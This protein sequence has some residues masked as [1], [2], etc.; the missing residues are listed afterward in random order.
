MGSSEYKGVY[1][2]TSK[3]VSQI[4][5]SQALKMPDNH[6]LKIPAVCSLQVHGEKYYLGTYDDEADAARAFDRVASVLGRPLNFPEGNE[7]EIVGPR[8]EG[9]DQAVAEAVKAAK[10]FLGTDEGKKLTE[11][12]AQKLRALHALRLTSPQTLT[13]LEQMGPSEY[14]G[15]NPHGGKWQSQIKVSQSSGN[16]ID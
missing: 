8:S 12:Q 13:I 15:V 7:S 14:K 4:K 16:I 1:P 5:V 11:V 6:I 10:T 2:D 9:A 3:W